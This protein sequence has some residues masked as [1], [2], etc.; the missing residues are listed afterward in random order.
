MPN[1]QTTPK[2]VTGLT[3]TVVN[4]TAGPANFYRHDMISTSNEVLYLQ[5]FDAAAASVTLG[6][7]VADNVIPI[8]NKGGRDKEA[9]DCMS[10]ATRMSCAL[11]TTPTGLTAPA[12]TGVLIAHVKE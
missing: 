2:V 1:I 11:T 5:L 9:S 6:T 4:V 8:L 3:A 7:T 10:F 12:S